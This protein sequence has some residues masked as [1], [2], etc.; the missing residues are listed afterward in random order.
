MD[1][2]QSKADKIAKMFVST[3]G[4][5]ISVVSSAASFCFHGYITEVRYLILKEVDVSS[6]PADHLSALSSSITHL[7]YID[8]VEGDI[9]PLLDVKI[10]NLSISNMELSVGD[11]LSMVSAM[12]N[13]KTLWL[14]YCGL[15]TLD[16]ET[17][18]TYTGQRRCD[19]I[20]CCHDTKK[21]YRR[22]L[23]S[24]TRGIDWKIGMENDS[25]IFLKKI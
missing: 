15:V 14:G 24:W 25:L 3:P 1:T 2:V 17:L 6:I 19:E 4:P 21:K 12:K 20:W 10:G 23:I 8:N 9:A 5:T 11:T 13:I 22:E 18:S 16:M 7:L